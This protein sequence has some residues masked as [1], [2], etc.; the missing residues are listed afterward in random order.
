[1]AIDWTNPPTY[2]PV[3]TSLRSIRG[4]S[5]P[6]LANR[7]RPITHSMFLTGLGVTT[8]F[9]LSA[10]NTN[11]GST[12]KSSWTTNFLLRGRVLSQGCTLALLLYCLHRRYTVKELETKKFN[13]GYKSVTL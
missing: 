10:M 9:F 2:I 5:S 3:G 1:M 13:D 11:R 4:G 8:L 6:P 7:L 12:P